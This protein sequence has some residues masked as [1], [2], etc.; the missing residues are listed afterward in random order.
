MEE[1]RRSLA[2]GVSTC[3]NLLMSLCGAARMESLLKRCRETPTL[4]SSLLLTGL[5]L[6]LFMSLYPALWSI[7]VRLKSV[8]TGSYVAGHHSVLLINSPNEQT[9]KEIARGVME[10][11]LAASVNILYRTSTMYYWKSEIQDATEI[12]ML[13]K[14][15]SSKI[16]QVVNYVRSVHPYGTPEI[17]SFPVEDG[18]LDYMKWIDEA[19]P[20]D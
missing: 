19:V 8:L 12:L 2:R 20:D 9:A 3:R 5:F 10:H 11:R 14:T 4:R 17:L 16:Q 13:V 1:V 15:R 6:F 18:S 7:G